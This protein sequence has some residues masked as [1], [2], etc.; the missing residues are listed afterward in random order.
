VVSRQDFERL[1]AEQSL[2]TAI[3]FDDDSTAKI[4]H[5]IGWGTIVYGA[6]DPLQNAYRL[7][8]RAVDVQSGEL[9][10]RGVIHQSPCQ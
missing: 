10:Q 7:L 4:G 6:V 2:Q 3:N 1:L 9:R 8:L 5:N